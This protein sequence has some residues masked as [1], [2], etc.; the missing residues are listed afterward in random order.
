MK[1]LLLL[2]LLV[3]L[4]LT[5]QYEPIE[6][7]ESFDPYPDTSDRIIH[8]FVEVEAQ[9]PGGFDSLR[10]FVNRNLNYPESSIM[11]GEQGRVYLSFV[12]ELDGSLSNITVMRGVSR[13]ID[14]EAVRLVS[15]MP[16]WIPGEQSGKTVR[17][18]FRIPLVFKLED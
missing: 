18:L 15:S 1:T 4:Q 16:N 6:P 13:L 5:A 9:Y 7:P 2:L 12:V 3:P 8:Q 17:S 14:E 10:V 11:A